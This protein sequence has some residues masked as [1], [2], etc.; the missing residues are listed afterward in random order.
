[1]NI[2][3]VNDD[4]YAAK[5]I[6]ALVNALA[7][8]CDVYVCAPDGQRSASSHSITLADEVFVREIEFP[9]AK[10]AYAISGTPA[11]CSKIGLQF[12]EAAGIH[13]D[14]VYSG[15][16]MGSNLGRDT[17]YSGT[18]GAAA[19]AA[20]DGIQ[21]VA[22]S[23]ALPKN[24]KGIYHFDAACKIAV[25]VMDKI[26]GK[27]DPSVV[28]SINTPNKPIDEL[29]GIK[30]PRLGNRYFI[31]R[32]EP[33]EGSEGYKLQ[34]APTKDDIFDLSAVRNGYA[35]VTPLQFDLTDYANLE[36]VRNWGL[37]L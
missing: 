6:Q 16:N 21:A 14:M 3:V 12:F 35:T 11:D 30:Y 24:D 9:N 33:V 32:F 20:L 36:K 18:V 10:K 27:L 37:S 31:D 34:G 8:V 28:I 15:I 5:G 19:E 4:G 25:D 26:Y 13:I 17:L 7:R 22:V 2:L 29:K 23:L 1:M